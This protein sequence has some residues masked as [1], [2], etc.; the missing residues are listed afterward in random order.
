MFCAGLVLLS[1]VKVLES[2]GQRG[3]VNGLRCFPN[4]RNAPRFGLS[5]RVQMF[6]R[7]VMDSCSWCVPG[8]IHGGL[9]EAL[10]R[11][12]KLI[13][14]SP[15][16]Q[17]SQHFKLWHSLLV[18]LHKLCRHHLF[19]QRSSSPACNGYTPQA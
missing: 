11:P 16:A 14:P 7:L 4:D 13:R 6:C 5:L 15:P 18:G 8:S 12:M 10:M 2:L 9:T 3:G 17:D 1:F 19:F